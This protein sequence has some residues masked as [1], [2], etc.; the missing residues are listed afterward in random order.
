MFCKFNLSI[1]SFP[2]PFFPGRRMLRRNSFSLKSRKDK[3]TFEKIHAKVDGLTANSKLP[4][5]LYLTRRGSGTGEGAPCLPLSFSFPAQTFLPHSS[6]NLTPLRTVGANID[7][8]AP[9]EQFPPES[10]VSRPLPQLGKPLRLKVSQLMAGI[11][12]KTAG[13]Y[14]AIPGDHT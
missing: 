12:I 11:F 7:P 2:T 10:L 4:S 8:A 5:K 9:F 3:I 1:R 6:P 13:N 14:L